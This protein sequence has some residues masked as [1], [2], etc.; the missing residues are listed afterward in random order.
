MPYLYLVSAVVLMTIL[1]LFGAGFNKKHE[2]EANVRPLYNMMLCIAG[3]VTWGIIFLCSFSFEWSVLPYSL[4]F[5]VCYAAITAS[6]IKALSEGPTLLTLLIQQLSLVGVSVWGFIFWGAWVPK[7]APFVLTGFLLVVISLVLCLYSGE[8][9]DKKIT[10][11]WLGYVAIMFVVTAGSS[12][13][14]RS[15]QNKFNGQY[16]SMFM[17]FGLLVALMISTVVFLAGEKPDVK[18]LVK[19][20]WFYPFGAGASSAL[21]N[22]FVVLLA[23]TTMSTN[24]IYPTLGVA[25]LALTSIASIYLFKEK[26]AWWQWVG[27]VIG[28]VAVLLLS[29]S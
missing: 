18:R 17:F 28:T 14:Q 24:L 26:L 10:W 23:S 4:M 2:G 5:G 1:N 7:L 27:V 12:I 8:K 9:S 15:Q 11:K 16:G 25:C 3:S 22:L 19:T 21:G 13:V 20:S 29:I 6:L